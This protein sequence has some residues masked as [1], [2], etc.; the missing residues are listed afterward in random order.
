MRR[1]LRA[2]LPEWVLVVE[3]IEVPESLSLGARPQYEAS[4]PSLWKR[5]M[6]IEA[7]SAAAVFGPMPG[8]ASRHWHV[9][10]PPSLRLSSSASSVRSASASAISAASSFTAMPSASGCR[11]LLADAHAASQRASLAAFVAPCLAQAA[12][13]ALLP[14][15]AIPA[16][17]P[18]SESTSSVHAA[19]RSAAASKAGS[20][21]RCECQADFPLVG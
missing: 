2:L 7:T 1:F 18:S 11:P 4:L 3:S 6:S 5:L 10:S 19:E 13:Y 17:P 21:S 14:A 12:P 9:S 20:D 8:T 15:S 16:A